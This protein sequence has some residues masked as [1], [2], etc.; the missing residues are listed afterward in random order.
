VGS[1][2]EVNSPVNLTA[3]EDMKEKLKEFDETR[4]KP[5]MEEAVAKIHDI[6]RDF[7][8]ERSGVSRS[9]HQLCVII[10]EAAEEDN[11]ETNKEVNLQVD[12]PRNSSKKE[13][14]K[15]HVSTG[16]WRII[17]SA[18]NHG[19]EVPADSRREVLM[20]YQYAL[21]QHKKKLREERD[22]FMRSRGENSMSS[23]GYWDEYNDASE[24]SMERHRDPKHNRRATA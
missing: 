14:E 10:T 19:I 17:M 18:I 5:D 8:I 20:G 24:S 4:R 16:E 1:S 13:K 12:K 11:H 22:M 3:T 15:I 9:V 6:S 7:T 23:G 21:H 2:S